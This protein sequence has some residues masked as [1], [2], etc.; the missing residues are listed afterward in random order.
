[1]YKALGSI[2]QVQN[3]IKADSRW[4]VFIVYPTRFITLAQKE[5]L[6]QTEF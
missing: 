5:L 1:M 2:F 3:K 4:L 6:C